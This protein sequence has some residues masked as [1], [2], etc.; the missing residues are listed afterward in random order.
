MQA[1]LKLINM[2]KPCCWPVIVVYG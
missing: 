2:H 1:E